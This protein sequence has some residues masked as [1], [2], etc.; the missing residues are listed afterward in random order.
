MTDWVEFVNRQCPLA[1]DRVSWD[2]TVLVIAGA[3]WSFSS[4]S[5][6]RLSR[7][8]LVS[9]IDDLEANHAL[10]GVVGESVMAIKSPNP[11]MGD[12][13]LLFRNGARIE[14]FVTSTMDPWV[15]RLPTGPILVPAPCDPAW[16]RSTQGWDQR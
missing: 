4:L 16:T 6:W 5:A 8:C 15:L 3:D 11:V 12:L 9:G 1:V 14:V 2:G 7:D 10:A 13:D